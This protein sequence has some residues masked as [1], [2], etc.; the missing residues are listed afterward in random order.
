MEQFGREKSHINFH[1]AVS[2]P[3]TSASH[4]EPCQFVTVPL[5]KSC[6][7]NTGK[8]SRWHKLRVQRGLPHFYASS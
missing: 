5:T 2:V 6:T 1:Y 3:T 4:A 8:Q 7:N